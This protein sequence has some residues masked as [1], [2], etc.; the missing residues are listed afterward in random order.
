MT[1]KTTA[2]SSDHAPAPRPEAGGAPPAAVEI[3]PGTVQGAFRFAGLFGRA[4]PVEI[5]IG[6]GKGRFLLDQAA[7]RPGVNFLGIEW[8]LKY[9]RL[10]AERAQRRALSNVRL[11]R[12]DARHVLADL[13]PD[14]SVS[15]VHVYCPDPWPKK[16]H[17]KRRLFDAAVAAD[18]ARV[19]I[20]AGYL[21]VSTDM[22]AY[23]EV[24]LEVLGGEPRLRPAADPLFPADDPRGR[25]SYEAK[26]LQAGRSIR[27]GC[28]ARSA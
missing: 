14:A 3:L 26:Y 20:P 13:V 12:A 6:S 23:F 28:W 5:E 4:G 25:T 21:H 22:P 15:R 10:T 19:L 8:S 18:L 1:W 7:A 9:L 17:H 16:R 11:Y 24:I 2:G 27:R